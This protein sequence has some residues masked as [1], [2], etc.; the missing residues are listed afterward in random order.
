MIYIAPATASSLQPG[1]WVVR[2]IDVLEKDF[3]IMGGW[4]FQDDDGVQHPLSFFQE[5]FYSILHGVGDQNPT[6]FEP[7]VNV[8]D[9]YQLAWSL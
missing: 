8:F 7:D 6:L 5:E 1:M 2:L 4:L 3:G 9:D